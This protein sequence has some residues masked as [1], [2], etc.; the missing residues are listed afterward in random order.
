[1][2]NAA[3][4]SMDGRA[5]TTNG[6]VTAVDEPREF[7]FRI[8]TQAFPPV[9]SYFEP[10][11]FTTSGANFIEE[12]RARLQQLIAEASSI[13]VIGVA[14]REQDAHIWGA[15]GRAKAAIYY[16]SGKSAKAA[17]G[18]WAEV[19]RPRSSNDVVTTKYW[20]ED[21]DG[22]ANHVAL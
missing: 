2:G 22:V 14:V 13:A 4:V 8:R 5:V 17:F 1:M 19:N 10:S 3:A 7:W 12:Q 21:F 11:K 6:P 15:L 20:A 16:C 18:T 9:M